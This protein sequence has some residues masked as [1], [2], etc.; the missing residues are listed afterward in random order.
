[1]DDQLHYKLWRWAS[2]RHHN[3][4]RKWR[5]R[6]YWR[7]LDGR[8]TFTDGHKTL[9]R[10]A[11]TKIVRH[12]K[13]PAAK[14]PFDGDWIYWVKRIGKA[15][16][17]SQLSVKLLNTQHGKCRFCKL[18]FTSEDILEV[19]HTNGNHQDNRFANR[20]LMHGHCHDQVHNEQ[21]ARLRNVR[22]RAR[23]LAATC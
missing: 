7:H 5:F 19:H 9:A 21:M 6:R 11:D 20:A 8:F 1:M 22:Q 4:G 18:P 15:P 10:F 16:D 14:S 13:V 23:Q 3:K 2:W 12:P 17:R